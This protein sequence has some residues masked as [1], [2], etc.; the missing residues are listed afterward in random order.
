MATA[1]CIMIVPIDTDDTIAAIAPGPTS[2]IMEQKGRENWEKK[3]KKMLI[4]F[5]Q[6]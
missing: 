6:C 3:E 2:E 4:T 1:T 5:W